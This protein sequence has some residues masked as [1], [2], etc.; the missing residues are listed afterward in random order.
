MQDLPGCP[1]KKPCRCKAAA[2]KAMEL[3]DDLAETHLAMG[4]VYVGQD[5]DWAAAEKELNLRTDPRFTEWLQRLKL[6]P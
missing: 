5:H 4:N 2:R 3:D 1:T 6:A